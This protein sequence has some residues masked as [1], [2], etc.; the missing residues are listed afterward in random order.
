MTGW[1]TGWGL[2]FLVFMNSLG[3]RVLDIILEPFAFIGGEYGYTIL[4]P[5]LFWSINDRLGRRLYA[6]A[7]SKLRFRDY[8]LG[9]AIGLLIPMPLMSLFIDR[10]TEL[11]GSF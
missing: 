1:E 9:S 5:V 4:M 6:L 11:L 2:E 10:F 3:G 8:L 7:M